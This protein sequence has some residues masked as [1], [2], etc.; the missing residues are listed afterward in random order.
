MAGDIEAKMI[1]HID[2]KVT[3]QTA[4]KMRIM[5]RYPAAIIAKAIA[6]KIRGGR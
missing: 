1:L 6:D 2:I 4:V 5:G 3:W